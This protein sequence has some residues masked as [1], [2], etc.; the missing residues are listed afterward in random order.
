MQ[1]KVQAWI[2]TKPAQQK[3]LVLFHGAVFPL[4]N[5][6]CATAQSLLSIF[7]LLLLLF[8]VA[9][10]IFLVFGQRSGEE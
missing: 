5:N 6:N 3:V 9:V 7:S 8:V 1:G 10:I 2:K 4:Y